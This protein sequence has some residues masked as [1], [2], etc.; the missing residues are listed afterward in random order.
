M[1]KFRQ[2]LTELSARETIMA[3]YYRFTLLF[4]YLGSLDL[5]T[6][7]QLKVCQV[8]LYNDYFTEIHVFNSNQTP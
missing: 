2:S 3:E 1:G 6:H 7:F 5:S 4:L 8:S